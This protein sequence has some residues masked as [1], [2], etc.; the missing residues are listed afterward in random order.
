MKPINYTI[1]GCQSEPGFGKKAKTG[2]SLLKISILAALGVG[3]QYSAIAEMVEP[4]FIGKSYN[5]AMGVRNDGVVIVFGGSSR[6]FTPKSLPEDATPVSHPDNVLLLDV[7][8]INND[9]DS[10][11]G[12]TF[13]EGG[14]AANFVN[15][16]IREPHIVLTSETIQEVDGDY[17]GGTALTDAGEVFIWENTVTSS[18]IQV[19]IPEAVKEIDGESRLAITDSGDLYGWERSAA[20][21]EVEA[22]LSGHSV[23]EVDGYIWEGVALTDS[24]D[25]YSWQHSAASV[26]VDV[27]KFNF[28][29]SGSVEEINGRFDRGVALTDSGTLYGWQH[30]NASLEITEIL[31]NVAELEG[32]Y[33]YIA[34]TDS[35]TVH[36]VRRQW[37]SG[38]TTW[39]TTQ[40]SGLPAGIQVQAVYTRPN[41]VLTTDGDVYTWD[42][43]EAAEKVLFDKPVISVASGGRNYGLVMLEDGMMCGWGNNHYGQLGSNS[44]NPVPKTSPVCLE[45]LIVEL[46]LQCDEVST[47]VYRTD[48]NTLTFNNLAMELYSPWTDEPSGKFALFQASEGTAVEMAAYPGFL[49][50][51]LP[52]RIEMNF[53][54]TIDDNRCYP[55]YS[56]QQESLTFP[57]V[58]V[59]LVG[60]DWN[61][62]VT[63]TEVVDCY[64]ATMKQAVTQKVFRLT[65]AESIECESED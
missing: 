1:N 20:S 25:I 22:I 12:V 65:D 16:E 31:S 38:S 54:E 30:S 43:N 50:F 28:A 51:R 23:K 11:G 15:W 2:R 62:T 27:E 52:N 34:L 10:S 21:V 41:V 35:G 14:V 3:F 24:G 18:P 44:P 29:G 5:A 56:A 40:V 9:D 33:D 13:S 63:E 6:D 19:N 46:P 64:T 48:T 7:A 53:V 37:N 55:T 36:D 32:D 45:D 42:N 17:N 4:P 8:K 47:T 60:V 26:Q 39:E 57:K 61:N 59:P 58:Q 49:D